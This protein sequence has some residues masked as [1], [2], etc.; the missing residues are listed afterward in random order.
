[1]TLIRS[2]RGPNPLKG[3]TVDPAAIRTVGRDLQRPECILAERDGTLWSADARGGVMRI[4]PDGRQTLVAQTPDPHFDLSA[5]AANSL[6]SGTLPNGL[7]FASNGDILISNFG[8]GFDYILMAMAPTLWWLFAGRIISGI[9]AASISTSYAYI[10]DVTPAEQRSARFGMLGVAFG[11]G[12]VFGPAL[13]GLAGNIDPRL[14]FWIAAGLSLL[15]GVYGLLILPESLPPERRVP[16]LWRKANPLGSLVLLRSHP[17]L[18]GL[19]ITNFLGHLAHASLPGIGVLY[20]MYRYGW[21]ERTVGLTMAGVGL[22]AIVVQGSVIGPVV[23]RFGERRAL[24]MGL[25][26]GAAGFTVFGLAP[27]GPVFWLGIP[28]MALWGLA[29]PSAQGLMSRRIGPDKQGQ[30]QGANASLMGVANLIGPGLF[31]LTF[32][33]AID[34]ATD[35]P[36]AP[37]LVAAMLLSLAIM[38]ALRATGSA[39]VPPA[40]T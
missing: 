23:K 1:M 13:G 6:L 25:G 16:F 2:G 32:A 3:F 40:V 11:A 38:V 5:S 28:L 39:G 14:P 24:V 8:L 10:A 17:E 21:N 33:F 29:N 19:A 31:T 37:H 20:M 36:G 18:S 12:F 35:L 7:A 27:T 34:A 30:L 9:T 15:N 4:G 22:A 26:F